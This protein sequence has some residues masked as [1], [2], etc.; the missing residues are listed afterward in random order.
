MTQAGANACLAKS[1]ERLLGLQGVLAEAAWSK[2]RS[3]EES[4]PKGR[5]RGATQDSA[6]RSGHNRAFS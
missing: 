2:T 1:F 4:T 3:D 5:R 6:A